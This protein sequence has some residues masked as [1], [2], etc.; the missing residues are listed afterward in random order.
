ME[1][2][3]EG[4]RACTHAVPHTHTRSAT[5]AHTQ[6]HARTDTHAHAAC[7]VRWGR[8]GRSVSHPPPF[9]PPSRRVHVQAPEGLVAG[10]SGTYSAQAMQQA[11]MLA[12]QHK[13]AR[14][15]GAGG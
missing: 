15:A 11:V 2:V 8:A 10:S 3:A 5:H 4:T 9:P 13:G 12:V 6:R 14:A 1:G 7:A